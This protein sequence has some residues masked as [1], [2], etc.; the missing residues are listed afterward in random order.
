LSHVFQVR[1]LEKGIDARPMRQL[2]SLKTADLALVLDGVR[3]LET[4]LFGA[5]TFPFP[6]SGGNHRF[7]VLGFVPGK[8]A[9]IR[10]LARVPTVI[11]CV[12]IVKDHGG[13]PL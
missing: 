11:W 8:P 9:D 3:R 6:L 10:E 1:R 5:L 2:T 13:P 4:E 12:P 7:G